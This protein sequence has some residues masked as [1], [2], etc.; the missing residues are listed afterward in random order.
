MT[1]GRT[2][3]NHSDIAA[4][5]RSVGAYVIDCS[6]VG[7]G[8]PDLIVMFRGRIYLVEVKDGAKPPSRRRLTPAQQ[9]LHVEVERSGC[10]V[11]I[12]KNKDEALALLGA[13]RAA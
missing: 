4:V 13:R 11:H 3:A 5:M 9:V 10:K 6:Q 8:F 2:D 7:A 1:Y 12:V